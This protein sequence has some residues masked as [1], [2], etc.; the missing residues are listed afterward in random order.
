MAGCIKTLGRRSDVAL[1][2]PLSGDRPAVVIESTV[3]RPKAF[4]QRARA[5]PRAGGWRN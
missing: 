1:T 4:I 5:S 3:Q 2:P